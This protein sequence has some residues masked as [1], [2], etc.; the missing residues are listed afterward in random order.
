MLSSLTAIL[1]KIIS[2]EE[3]NGNDVLPTMLKFLSREL[4]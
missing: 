2:Q 4:S 3:L 1:I